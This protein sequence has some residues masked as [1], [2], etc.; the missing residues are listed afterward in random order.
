M[1]ER[2]HD[3]RAKDL[4]LKAGIG[5]RYSE[6]DLARFIYESDPVSDNSSPE[7]IM[8]TPDRKTSRALRILQPVGHF[9]N[10][11]KDLVALV[12]GLPLSYVLVSN[13]NDFYTNSQRAEE[14]GR[15]AQCNK[16]IDGFRTTTSTDLEDPNKAKQACIDLLRQHEDLVEDSN[17]LM[18]SSEHAKR[19][20]YGLGLWIV[21]PSTAAG[22]YSLGSKGYRRLKE[23]GS[24][25]LTRLA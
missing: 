4:G 15:Q 14:A 8:T 6:E 22:A 9:L 11:R 1:Q 10:S 3:Q 19:I 13:A 21:I 23:V 17:P 5:K 16:L 12:V 2:Y 25:S 20:G 24:Q 18:M 7:P